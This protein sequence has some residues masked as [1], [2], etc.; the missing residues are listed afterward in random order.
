MTSSR[1]LLRRLGR[2]RAGTALR[3]FLGPARV[4]ALRTLALPGGGGPR[5]DIREALAARRAASLPVGDPAA[6]RSPQGW[7]LHDPRW[8]P[9]GVRDDNL[10]QTADALD[11]AGITYALLRTDSVTRHALA[12]S[13]RDRARAVAALAAAPG[14]RTAQLQEVQKVDAV[15]HPLPAPAVTPSTWPTARVVRVFRLVRS[16][17]GAYTVG[18]RYGC[19][20]EFW[21]EGPATGIAKPMALAPRPN[22][23][24]AFLPLG[25]LEDTEP[26]EI[27][28]RTYPRPRIFSRTMLEDVTFDI[29]IVCTWVNGADP[30]WRERMLRTQERESSVELHPEASA[31]NRFASRDELRYLLRSVQS[32]APW[33]RHVWLVTDQQRPGWLAEDTPGLTVVDHTE[34]VDD[35][36]VLPLFNSNAIISRLHHIPGLAEHYLYLNDDMFFGHD[37]APDA[38][39]HPSGVAKLFP[40]QLRR[41]FGPASADDEPHMNISRNIRA[42]LEDRFGTTSHAGHPAHALPAGPEPAARAGGALPGGVRRRPAAPVPAPRRHRGGPAAALLPADRRRRCA[43]VDLA[44]T[45]STSDSPRRTS[46]CSGCCGS[47]TGRCS[48]STTPRRPGLCR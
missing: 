23:A 47:V 21:D 41:P 7:V 32:Y 18:E 35:P 13:V 19:D 30:A 29:D 6:E 16:D 38:F 11:A 36:S 25:T 31:P 39:F 28:G 26:V 3:D 44:T 42:L 4:H 15:G 27:G 33:V 20:V 43:G 34:I 22:V 24:S 37:V 17:P 40:A 1:D 5:L 12:V 8:Q 45:T 48:V 9:Q 2:T 14:L 46:G 10:A